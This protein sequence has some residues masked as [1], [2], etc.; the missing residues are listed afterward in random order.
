MWAFVEVELQRK[1]QGDVNLKLFSPKAAVTFISAL[2]HLV[3]LTS[4]I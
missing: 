2:L 3:V 1:T 4:V